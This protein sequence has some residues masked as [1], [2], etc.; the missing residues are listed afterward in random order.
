MEETHLSD[1]FWALFVTCVDPMSKLSSI[2]QLVATVCKR[3]VN[4]D[5]EVTHLLDTLEA[6][7]LEL[8][9][10]QKDEILEDI[11]IGSQRYLMMPYLRAK[12]LES[13][14]NS[15]T[16]HQALL[17]AKFNYSLFVYETCWYAREKKEFQEAQK[18]FELFA[19]M[20]YEDLSGATKM[21]AEDR[22]SNVINRHRKIQALVTELSKG[23]SD[24]YKG[25]DSSEV[26]EFWEKLLLAGVLD[27]TAS[28]N[29]INQE[30]PLLVR[31]Q[32]E[33]SKDEGVGLR[34]DGHGTVLSKPF[35]MKIVRGWILNFVG[36][37]SVSC[38]AQFSRT[39]ETVRI[40][41]IPAW[42]Q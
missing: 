23:L 26:A 3:R 22:R 31:R 41:S 36:F 8:D 32:K 24:A 7:L 38:S 39:A 5:E 17:K 42:P 20:N 27:S 14:A 2:S 35:I 15:E 30:L 16:R 28:I 10:F 13:C 9:P 6:R 25:E 11:P 29:L 33:E 19:N 4:S 40:S 37:K 34:L 18:D 21:S 1:M 12:Q